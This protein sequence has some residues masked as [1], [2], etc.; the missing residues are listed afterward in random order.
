MKW[1]YFKE[2]Y[3]VTAAGILAAYLWG[4]HVLQGSGGICV[5]IE[6]ASRGIGTGLCRLRWSVCGQRLAMAALGG[7]NRLANQ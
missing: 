6:F 1:Q 4:E 2:S 5:F 7:Q 3:I